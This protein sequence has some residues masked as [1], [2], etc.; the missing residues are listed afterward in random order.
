LDKAKAKASSTER[1]GGT[2]TSAFSRLQDLVSAIPSGGGPGMKNDLAEM[3]RIRA[4]TISG[5]GKPTDQLSPHELHSKIW[6][7]LSLRDKS[8]LLNGFRGPNDSLMGR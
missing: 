6:A 2:N 7:I 5:T 4:E 3:Q 1:A 8:K